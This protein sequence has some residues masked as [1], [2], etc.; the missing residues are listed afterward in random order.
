MKH[1]FLYL[2]LAAMM[3][4]S[5]YTPKAMAARTTADG[6]IGMSMPEADSVQTFEHCGLTFPRKT[7]DTKGRV[8]KKAT[9]LMFT[10][11]DRSAFAPFYARLDGV[12]H[13]E[14]TRLNVLHIGG[15]HVQAGIYS[16]R[17]RDNLLD[18]S[19]S[20]VGDRGFT[21]PFDA[22]RTNAPSD[23]KLKSYGRWTRSRCISQHP[24]ATL[25]ICGAAAMTVDPTASL[26]YNLV[27]QKWAFTQL[28][29]LGEAASTN[30][31]PV[32]VLADGT[33]LKPSTTDELGYVFTLPEPVVALKVAFEG[34]GP[35]RMFTLRGLIPSSDRMGITYSGT[36]INGAST[37]SWLRCDKF[38]DELKLLPPDLVI[39]GI[40]INDANCMADRFS[41]DRFKDN[42]RQVIARIREASPNA[43]F[44]FIT[45]NDCWVSSQ[46][47]PATSGPLVQQAFMDLAAETGGAVFDVFQLMGGLGASDAWMRQGLMRSDHI[48]F[49]ADG[50]RLL[51]DLLYNALMDDYLT[52]GHRH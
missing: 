39:F 25:G 15:S 51:G 10:S 1:T 7:P 2:A 6:R 19:P 52:Y 18:I 40:G 29:V 42:Y 50:Y 32:V 5:M 23:Y 21:F 3:C 30:T 46:S 33:R 37:L 17:M 44:V 41:A 12:L 8:D 22:I 31:Y 47:R 34:V 49:T 11:D 28:R 14:P 16:G 38:V 20:A 24:D 9:G 48:H 43:A 26:D 4:G 13:G 35:G 27:Q 45:N 36:G